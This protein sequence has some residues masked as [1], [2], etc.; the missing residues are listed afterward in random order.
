MKKHTI[1]LSVIAIM[2]VVAMS[3]SLTSA[4]TRW[5]NSE[6]ERKSDNLFMEAQKQYALDSL[7]N[8]YA[9]L[10]ESYRLAPENTAV[11]AEYGYFKQLIGQHIKNPGMVESGLSLMRQH[12]EVVPEDYYAGERY[13]GVCENLDEMSEALVVWATLDSIYPEKE[14]CALHYAG[15]LAQYGDS[16]SQR[17][18]YDI[19]SRLEV[20]MGRSTQLTAYKVRY[21]LF[22]R[23][24]VGVVNE[25]HSLMNSSP[26]NVDFVVTAGEIY[27]YLEMPDSALYYYN[28]ACEIDS[29]NGQAF[30]ALANHYYVVGDSVAF[31]RAVFKAMEKNS[32]ELDVKL[33]IFRNYISKLYT[34]STQHHRIQ[35]LFGVLLEQNPHEAELRDLYYAYL[36]LKEDYL[37]AAEQLE[38]SLN[39]DPSDPEKWRALMGL[40]IQ[41]KNYQKA[42]DSG[43]R[44]IEL[45]PEESKI[46]YLSGICYNQMKDTAN[47][48]S[49]YNEAL[50]FVSHDDN[51]TFSD[52]L[53]SIGDVYASSG[54]LD[55]AVGYYEQ[56]VDANPYNLTA[57]NNCA[58]FLAC[59]GR[60]LERAEK[61]SQLTLE[62]DPHN[63]TSLD[64]Y[65]WVKFKKKEY[66]LAKEYIDE[67]MYYLEEPSAEVLHHAG[68]IYF[69]MG[70]PDKALEFWEDALELEPENELL[71]RKVKH[72]TY[73]YK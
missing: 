54:N 57:M 11:G 51:E 15:L 19:F 47:A 68:D 52:I 64:T 3:G 59:E 60:D 8:Y 22:N 14:E 56:S 39:I 55:V 66:A 67:A 7:D 6:N 27:S 17:K 53:C 45:F 48:L 70:E 4:E 42:V 71:Q 13:A 49:Y 20:S 50:K 33:S 12:F 61:M 41:A 18:A 58:Y 46:Y 73:F 37:G 10:E 35:E 32:L 9:L 29:T 24:T 2:V 62:D 23:D 21:H 1:L 34:D 30:Y 43:N 31:D 40:Y 38:Y 26:K 65:A 5:G 25:L 16:T 72:K 44:A 36:G 28:R 69:M 63:P